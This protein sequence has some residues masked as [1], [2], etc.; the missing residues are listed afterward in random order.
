MDEGGETWKGR[1]LPSLPLFSPG[2][3]FCFFFKASL[4]C[5][6]VNLDCLQGSIS[7]A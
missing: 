6:D 2:F 3:W 1:C 4:P 5:F 7:L